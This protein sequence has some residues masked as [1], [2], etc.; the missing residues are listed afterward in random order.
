MNIATLDKS[1]ASQIIRYMSAKKYQIFSGAKQFNIVY[2]EGMNADG[3][4]NSDRPNEFNDRRILIEITDKPRIVG[5]WEATTEP[6]DYYTINP[7]NP[8]G[9]ARI[10][11]GQYQA[12]RIGFHGKRDTHEALIQVSEVKVWRDYNKDYKRTGDFLTRGLYGINQHWGYDLPVTKVYN[13][14]AGCLVGRSRDS[15]KLFMKLV[16]SDIRYERDK[17]YTFYTAILP[18]D[19][20]IREFPIAS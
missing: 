18:G 17:N 10:A 19:E 14:S 16:K 11:F 6:G 13:A 1:L 7:M 20:L 9:A 4:L 15:H 2:V 5:S 12:W 8:Q 3:T